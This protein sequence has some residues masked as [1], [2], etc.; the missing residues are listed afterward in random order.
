MAQFSKFEDTQ[1][2]FLSVL[3]DVSLVML[4]PNTQVSFIMVISQP[5][6]FLI[7][8]YAPPLTPFLPLTPHSVFTC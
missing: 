6:P 7:L 5:T 3:I 1:K 2:L 8:S 4:N